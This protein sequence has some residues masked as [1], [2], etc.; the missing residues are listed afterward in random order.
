LVKLVAACILVGEAHKKPRRE[1]RSFRTVTKELLEMRDWFSSEG[2]T[3]V[4]MESTGVYWKPVYAILEDDFEI[5]VGNAQHI[6]TCP[7]AR[8][9]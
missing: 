3:H 6:R 7:A 8:R 4:G 5:I 1:V 9:T 2:V